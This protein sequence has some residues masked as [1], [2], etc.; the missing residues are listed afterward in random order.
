MK[1]FCEIY[2]LN[3]QQ[4]YEILIHR[5]IKFP[6]YVI[7]ESF[8]QTFAKFIVTVYDKEFQIGQFIVLFHRTVSKYYFM[9]LFL[10][11]ISQDY[12]IVM[13]QGCFMW[14]L[15]S[16]IHRAVSKYYFIVLF[17][18]TIPQGCFVGLLHSIIHGTISKCTQDYFV[19]LFQKNVSQGNFMIISQDYFTV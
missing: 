18:R 3:N 12:F 5:R 2:L 11:I 10:S 6:N 8:L 17:N 19:I 14:L 7:K 9:G 13:S 4:F 1:S 15:R 16:I